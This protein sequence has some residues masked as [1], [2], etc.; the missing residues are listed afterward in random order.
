[1]VFFIPAT[2]IPKHLKKIQKEDSIPERRR[3]LPRNKQ[4]YE[5]LVVSLLFYSF[6][7]G[8]IYIW[9][10]LSLSIMLRYQSVYFNILVKH[11]WVGF[12]YIHSGWW[13]Y[14]ITFFIICQLFLVCNIN[15]WIMNNLFGI[16]SGINFTLMFLFV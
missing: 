8:T 16:C 6:L 2:V 15:A 9:F 12:S 4:T 11:F 10:D 5:K 3:Y 1:M 14:L 13:K 7:T